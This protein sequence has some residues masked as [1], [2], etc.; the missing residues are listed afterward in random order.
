MSNSVFIVSNPE[1]RTSIKNVILVAR[2][3]EDAKKM[4]Q[5][6]LLD[7]PDKYIVDPITNEAS[8]TMF[9]VLG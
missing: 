8:A 3:R 9:V 4:A 2:G 5:P 7:D 6:Y 1:S